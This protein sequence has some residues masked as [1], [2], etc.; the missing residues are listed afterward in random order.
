MDERVLGWLK[1]HAG[2]VFESPR[3]KAFNRKVMDIEIVSVG[4]ERVKIH[5]VGSIYEALPLFFWM[6]DRTLEYLNQNKAVPIRLGSKVQPPYEIDTV[7]GQIWQKPYPTGN[8]SYKVASHVCDILALAGLVEYLFVDTEA[9]RNIQ[10]VKL[11]E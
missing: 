9:R 8:S 6:F 11:K 1:S 7:E 2:E 5:F 3:K 4:D 10:A